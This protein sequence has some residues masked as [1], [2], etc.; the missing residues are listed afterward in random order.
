M[1]E[2]IEQ[3]SMG[4]KSMGQKSMG[5]KFSQIESSLKIIWGCL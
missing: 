5:Q 2:S 1:P 4:Q 3:K